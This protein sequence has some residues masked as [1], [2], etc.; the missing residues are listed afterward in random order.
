MTNFE[1]GV[2]ILSA[3]IA[4]NSILAVMFMTAG[5]AGRTSKVEDGILKCIGMFLLSSLIAF[6]VYH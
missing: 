2:F 5:G 4:I 3:Y 1:T 6:M